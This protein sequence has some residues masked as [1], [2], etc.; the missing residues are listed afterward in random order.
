MNNTPLDGIRA[1]D[2]LFYI[3]LVFVISQ[4]PI[5]CHLTVLYDTDISL[6]WQ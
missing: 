1:A 6:S 2:G 4:A 5:T 3:A